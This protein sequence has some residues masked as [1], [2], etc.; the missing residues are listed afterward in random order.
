MKRATN[1]LIEK[2]AAE[3]EPVRSIKFRDG[4][5]L[6]SLAMLITLLAVELL[7]GLWLGAWT[8]QASGF[9]VVTSGLLLILGCASTNSVLRMAS[10]GVGNNHDGPLWAMAMITV[11]PLAAVVVLLGNDRGL[12]SISDHHGLACFGAG[13]AASLLCAV[14]LVFWLRRGAPVSPATAGLYIG[15]ASTALGSAAYGLACAADSVVHLGIWHVAP[16]IAG[17]LIGRFLLPSLLRW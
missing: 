12:A 11:L 1:P 8:G 7:S 5:V 13:L 4:L 14:A 2:M 6:V 10:P 9:F 3:L 17:A 15:V 16:V